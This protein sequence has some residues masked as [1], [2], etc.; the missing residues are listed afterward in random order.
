[1]SE[2]VFERIRGQLAADDVV[3]YMKGTPVF[4]MCGFSARV[5]QILSDAGVKFQSYNVLED[6]ELRQG[7]KDFSNWPTFPQL[8]VKGELVGGCD[9]VTEMAQTGELQQLLAEKGVVVAA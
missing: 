7:L 9:I 8:Y 2:A 5:V 4:P 6:P 3:L 1:M